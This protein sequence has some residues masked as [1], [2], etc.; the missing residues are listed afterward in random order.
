M[1]FHLINYIHP[2]PT[3]CQYIKSFASEC[4]QEESYHELKLI[5]G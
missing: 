1:S 2:E 3:D 5:G 4:D